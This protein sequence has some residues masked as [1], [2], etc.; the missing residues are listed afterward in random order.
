MR[1]LLALANITGE[2]KAQLASRREAE[3]FRYAIYKYRQSQDIGLDLLITIDDTTVV[4]TKP[5]PPVVT[6][7]QEQK[8]ISVP[9][10]E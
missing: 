5:K 8:H 10:A 7:L 4:A 6:I 1:E 3:L 9:E 2:A